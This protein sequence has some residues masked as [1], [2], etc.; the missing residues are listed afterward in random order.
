MKRF[1]AVLAIAITV[2]GVSSPAFT[3][4][5]A[6]D[7]TCTTSD[8]NGGCGPYL[9]PAITNSNGYNVSVIQDGWNCDSNCIS[10]TLTAT[11]PGNWSVTAVDAAGNGAVETYPD[12][13]ALYTGVGNTSP[14]ISSFN[15]IYSSFAETMNTTPGTIAEAGYDIWTNNYNSDVMVWVDTANRNMGG[16]SE[17]A[18]ATF[19]GQQFNL[20]R[21]GGYGGELIWILNGNEQSGTV[22]LKVML[23]WLENHHY[24]PAGDGISQMDFGWEICST[25]G[26]P[27]TFQVSNYTLNTSPADGSFG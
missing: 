2:L 1:L 21:Y 27:E 20:W 24:I 25:G 6:A 23:T 11:D 16:A 22:H 26:V 14:P 10:Q 5:R 3:S 4:P 18:S 17:L 8:V 9:Y 12:V 13:Q 19:F 15:H 7:S